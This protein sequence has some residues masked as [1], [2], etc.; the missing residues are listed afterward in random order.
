MFKIDNNVEKRYQAAIFQ[1]AFA[2]KIKSS[3]AEESFLAMNNFKK[4]Q[5]TEDKIKILNKMSI[6]TDIHYGA[7]RVKAK[8]E[9]VRILDIIGKILTLAFYIMYII[10]NF[11]IPA[12]GDYILIPFLLS[13]V[14]SIA[15]SKIKK[16]RNVQY[17]AIEIANTE[18]Q[19][20]EKT[21]DEVSKDSFV[22]YVL[23]NLDN[24]EELYSEIIKH[25][26]SSRINSYTPIR[27]V[28]KV[29]SISRALIIVL[30][31]VPIIKKF[32]FIEK[33]QETALPF[34]I[35]INMFTFIMNFIIDR[36][37]ERSYKN[38]VKNTRG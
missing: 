9:S 15:T 16:K 20:Y 34:V 12:V 17:N 14:L 25:T 32:A 22:E 18:F 28:N 11:F 8:K 38:I 10:G 36:I 13:L 7:A 4:P 31:L 3:E 2:N 35:Y 23:N 26:E 5:N 29:Q 27:I 21:V 33:V 24:N 19:K 6:L 30:L 1:F 37:V